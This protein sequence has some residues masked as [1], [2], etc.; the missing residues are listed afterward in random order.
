MSTPNPRVR[1]TYED[2]QTLPEFM[3]MMH[4]VGVMEP[5]L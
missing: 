3:R 5:Y 1:F 4:L 2:Y